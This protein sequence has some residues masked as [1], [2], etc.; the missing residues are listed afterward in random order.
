MRVCSAVVLL[1]LV[2]SKTGTR[3]QLLFPC[4]EQ[5]FTELMFATAWAAVFVPVST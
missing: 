5:L 3:E 1:P 4:G 2:E